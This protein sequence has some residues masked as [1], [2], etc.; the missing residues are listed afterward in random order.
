MTS[1]ITSIAGITAP[2]D[3]TTNTFALFWIFPLLLLICLTYRAVKIENFN[4][5]GLVFETTKMFVLTVLVMTAITAVLWAIVY[6]A[7]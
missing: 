5:R 1:L 2:M 6:Y 3:I 7:T 4:L